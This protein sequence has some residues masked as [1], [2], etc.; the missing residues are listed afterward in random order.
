MSS[1]FFF[2]GQGSQTIGMGQ[3][4]FQE[5]AI[6]KARFEEA[7]AVL[8]RPL[9]KLCFEGPEEELKDT[10]NTQPALYVCGAIAADLLKEAGVAPDAVAGHSL[11]EY[12]ALYGAGVLS[13]AD[14]LKLVAARGRLMAEA[15]EA[16]PG[17]MA[18]VMGLDMDKIRDLCGEIRQE[19][20]GQVDVANDNSPG[21]TVISGEKAAVEAACE[22]MK[23]A[24]AKR[25]LV[26]PVSGAFHSPLMEQAREALGAELDKA[27]W[28]APQCIFVPNV[29]AVPE[30]DPGAIRQHLMDQLT[31][32]VRWTESVQNLVSGGVTLAVEAGPGKVLAGLVKRIDKS[33]TVLPGDSPDA[34]GQAVEKMQA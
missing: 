7:D 29:T 5:T 30:K 16:R 23:A 12:T 3:A 9:S 22:K 11:G 20:A 24:G 32:A 21:Q 6:G 1:A 19:G 26:L 25:A 33:L 14:G 10:R 18:A 4:F 34:I 17:A 13:F 2:P 8:G 15:A 28:K 31:G 27:E